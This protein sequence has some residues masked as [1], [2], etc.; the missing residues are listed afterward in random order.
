MGAAGAASGRAATLA[1][2]KNG[3]LVINLTTACAVKNRML[4]FYFAKIFEIDK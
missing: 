2:L 4:Q 3:E 1:S